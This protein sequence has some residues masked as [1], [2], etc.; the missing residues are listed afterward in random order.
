[1][2]TPPPPPANAAPCR[3]RRPDLTITSGRARRV[4]TR[5]LLGVPGA[6]GLALLLAISLPV[7]FGC[8]SLVVMSGSMEPAI[9]TGS[10]VVVKRIPAAEIAVGDVISFR[11]PEDPGRI[12]THRAQAVAVEGGSVE[13]ETRGD[14]NTGAESWDIDATGTVGRVAFHVPLLGYLVAPLQGT[15]PR[16]LLVVVPA[17]LLCGF[18]IA[19]IW[20]PGTSRGRS[21]ARTQ[22][23]PAGRSGA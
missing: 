7:L 19:D 15:V 23:N 6:F 9:P 14:A 17:L 3:A 20:R 16:L 12:L 1:M 21:R 5:A 18:L 4:A 2:M 13:V 11:S 10:V 22:L 8:R